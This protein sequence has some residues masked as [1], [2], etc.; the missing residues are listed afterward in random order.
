MASCVGPSLLSRCFAVQDASFV[1]TDHVTRLFSCF[2]L[3]IS[4]LKIVNFSVNYNRT[5][6]YSQSQHLRVNKLLLLNPTHAFKD[7]QI[8]NCMWIHRLRRLRCIR[9]SFLLFFWSWRSNHNTLVHKTFTWLGCA[10]RTEPKVLTQARHEVVSS[11][12]TNT[13]VCKL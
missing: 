12:T 2:A 7:L 13:S 3:F 6:S 9:K 10:N 1:K 11:N 5:L 4:T 8:R